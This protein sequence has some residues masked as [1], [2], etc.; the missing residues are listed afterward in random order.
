MSGAFLRSI[1]RNLFHR[2]E[3][4]GD[5][6]AEL[7]AYLDQ[8]TEEK[9]AKGMAPEEA[10]REARM[11]I[12]G[13]EQ[14]KEQVREVRSTASLDL[15]YQD[16][17]YGA[18]VLRKNPGF[19]LVAILTLALGIGANTAIFS[20][21]YGVLLRPLPYNTPEQLVRISTNWTGAVDGGVS[22]P[23][24][25]DYKQQA[26][27]L[28]SIGLH[29]P[30]ITMNVAFGAGE[31]ERVPR[32]MVT[33]SIFQ[34]LGVRPFLGRTFL[35]EEDVPG[36]ARVLLLSYG[37]WQR[38]FGNDRNVVG[39]I[40]NVG[41]YPFTIVGVMPPGFAF[42]T[43]ETAVWHPLRYNL[44]ERP[45][46]ARNLRVIARMKPGVQ[47]PRVQTELDTIARRLGKAYPVDYPRGSGFSPHVYSLREYLVGAPSTP[48]FF[49]LTAG[50][51]VRLVAGP[52]VSKSIN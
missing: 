49:R 45:R 6:D 18:R 40:V 52:P 26:G 24:Y 8:L 39:K 3:V 1:W 43:P 51:I 17:R 36:S 22:G 31:P 37:L 28:Q 46:G 4:D 19:S 30:V 13:V 44:A 12:G 33:S 35:P 9:V 16:L 15:L 21:V 23:E 7:K 10:R 48:L 14:V 34:V 42:P 29:S 41:G 11:E 32:V 5:L 20:I 27:S 2:K 47:V 50:G 25:L 38:R